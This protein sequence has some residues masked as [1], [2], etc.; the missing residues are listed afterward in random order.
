MSGGCCRICRCCG[1]RK[2]DGL[3]DLVSNVYGEEG[4]LTVDR[5]VVVVKTVF[6]LTTV[7]VENGPTVDF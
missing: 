7:D 5:R 3:W 2:R 1:C 4:G 6:E